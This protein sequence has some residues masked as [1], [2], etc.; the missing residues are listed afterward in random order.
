[1]TIHQ[2]ADVAIRSW[3]PDDLWLLERLLGDPA[4]TRHLGGPEKPDEIAARHQR[5]LASDPQR[6]GLFAVVAAHEAEPV[7]WVGY[8]ESEWGGE[9]VWECGWHVLPERQGRGVATVAVNLLLGDARSRGLHRYVHA[10]PAIEN[11]ASNALCRTLGFVSLGAVDVEYP[12]GSMMRSN[13]WRFDL[14]SE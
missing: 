12:V 1:V 6:N 5:Y 7:G 2:D 10:F 9:R 14:G 11:V 13:D 4:M 3:Q 8:W